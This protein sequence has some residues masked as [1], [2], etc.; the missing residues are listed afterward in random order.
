[1]QDVWFFNEATVI[2]CLYALV[3]SAD[4]LGYHQ[5]TKKSGDDE[6]LPNV[7]K[8]KATKQKERE[9]YKMKG[10]KSSQKEKT[11]NKDRSQGDTKKSNT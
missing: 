3:S 6:N 9:K 1:L 4:L 8:N 2:S 7:N 11:T 5:C 10:P